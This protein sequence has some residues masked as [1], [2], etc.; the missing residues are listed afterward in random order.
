MV[1]TTVEGVWNYLVW[2]V[3]LIVS[4][5]LGKVRVIVMVGVEVVSRMGKRVGRGWRRAC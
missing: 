5:G 4:W 3:V 2:V 1:G